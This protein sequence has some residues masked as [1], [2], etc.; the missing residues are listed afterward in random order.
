[1]FGLIVSMAIAAVP[2][3]GYC[4][5]CGE[6]APIVASATFDD[7]ATGEVC[8]YCESFFNLSY[9][10]RETLRDSWR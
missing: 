9:S 10:D 8:E 5:S 7:G 1:M 2:P 4:S 3:I 6:F